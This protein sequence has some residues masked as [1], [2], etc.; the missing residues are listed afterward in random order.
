MATVECLCVCT[1]SL[2]NTN[3]RPSSICKMSHGWKALSK[4][5]AGGLFRTCRVCSGVSC[6]KVGGFFPIP[7]V[8]QYSLAKTTLECSF[9]E[10]PG[11]CIL[12]VPIKCSRRNMSI[13]CLLA[14]AVTCARKKRRS[15]YISE[16]T[17]ILWR[18]LVTFCAAQTEKSAPSSC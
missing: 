8:V 10:N 5:G 11:S 15:N 18:L 13:S 9:P 6:S 17:E 2:A 12:I 4:H 1:L 14:N 3:P 16:G 7:T